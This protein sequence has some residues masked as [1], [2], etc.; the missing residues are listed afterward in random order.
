MG[1]S[2]SPS[3]S[4]WVAGASVFSGRPDPTWPIS[5]ELAEELI[6][7]WEALVPADDAIPPPPSLGYRGCFMRDAEGRTWTALRDLV[8]LSDE[9]TSATRRDEGHRFEQTVL[10]SAPEGMLPS[11]FVA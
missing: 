8:T 1:T 7:I 5:A 4:G 6:S 3:D 11:S 2:R 10:A 9:R